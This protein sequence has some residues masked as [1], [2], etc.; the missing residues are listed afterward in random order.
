VARE[1][2]KQI[3]NP[4]APVDPPDEEGE[5]LELDAPRGAIPELMRRALGLGLSGFFLTEETVRKAVGDTLPKDW[6]DFLVDQS[7]RT[8]AEF[9]ERISYEIGRSL[10][11]MD[12]A[13]VLT[14]L[15]EGRTLEI[16]AQVTLGEVEPGRQGPRVRF[17]GARSAPEEK[18]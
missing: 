5:D 6:A 11:G 17:R 8:R 12:L 9:M 2:G 7:E 3:P 15:L 1:R 18:D 13:D 14:R 10:E 16:K 4:K